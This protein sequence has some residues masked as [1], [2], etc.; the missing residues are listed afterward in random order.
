MNGLRNNI[1]YSIIIVLFVVIQSLI[2]HKWITADYSDNHF[3][4]GIVIPFL[5]M[6]NL[7]MTITYFIGFIIAGIVKKDKRILYLF[8]AF[9]SLIP[10]IILII[11]G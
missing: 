2:L 5:G 6:T 1:K 8:T 4:G 7:I 10:F 11:T 9:L 3:A